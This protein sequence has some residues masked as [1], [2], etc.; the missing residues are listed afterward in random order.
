MV[1]SLAL[2]IAVLAGVG[3]VA[4]HLWRTIGALRASAGRI[5]PRLEPLTRELGD[6][7][8]VTELE[9]AALQRSLRDL[10]AA[11]APRR[12]IPKTITVPDPATAHSPPGS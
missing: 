12:G 6:E 7:L 9:S 10:Q 1:V 5:R 4:A 8:A 3:L 2:L 11:R